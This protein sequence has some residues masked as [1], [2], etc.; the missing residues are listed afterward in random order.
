MTAITVDNSTNSAVRNLQNPGRTYNEAWLTW[1]QPADTGHLTGYDVRWGSGSTFTTNLQCLI[2][3]LTPGIEYTVQ[4]QPRRSQGQPGE[5]ATV[6]VTTYD[7]VPPTRPKRLKK[8]GIP[9]NRTMLTWDRAQDNVAVTGHL[10]SV[11]GEAE[12]ML[13]TA[14][15]T[16]LDMPVR[17][18]KAWQITAVDAAGN[19]SRVAHWLDV[20]PPSVPGGL[21]VILI[22]GSS[23]TLGWQASEDDNDVASYQIYVDDKLTGSVAQLRYTVSGLWGQTLYVFKVCAVDSAGN[24]S[25]FATLSVRTGGQDT[26][27][28][29]MPGGLKAE[30]VTQNSVLLDW[31]PS[32]DNVAVSGYE[33]YNGS[34]LMATVSTTRYE[35]T[36]LTGNT[37]YSFG[38]FALDA[39][40]NRSEGS[41]LRVT[42][43]P[44]SNAPTKLRLFRQFG[45]G[46]LSWE[47][48]LQA[49]VVDAY[50]VF[51]D[52]NFV[53][54]LR[55]TYVSLYNL[56]PGVEHLIEVRALINGALSDP[57]SIRG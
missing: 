52:G 54:E 5:S 56:T 22:N 57:A 45:R 47:P 7:R 29:T 9:G 23:I 21:E 25:G 12:V 42:T 1:Q 17:E 11:N 43:R 19:R 30:V 46:D 39:A 16:V 15:T 41:L 36:G 32:Q 38:V 37:T 26:T 55:E 2:S 14:S 18:V 44:E 33:I 51:L 20:T 13:S 53:R 35:A 3:P 28:P 48:P 49:G 8:E 27:P 10:L 31:D 34:W 4:V 6:K 24:Q 40:N 50:R